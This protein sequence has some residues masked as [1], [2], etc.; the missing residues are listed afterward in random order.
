MKST[1]KNLTSKVVAIKG[2]LDDLYGKYNKHASIQNSTLTLDPHC[3]SKE[4]EIRPSSIQLDDL[5]HT[6]SYASVFTSVQTLE[7]KDQSRPSLTDR[8]SNL[9]I[10]GLVECSKGSPR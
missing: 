5:G 6:P 2:K 9:V 7:R 10:F 1:I 8:K 3:T 4:S